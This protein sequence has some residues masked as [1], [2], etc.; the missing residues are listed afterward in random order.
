MAT[1]ISQ[2]RAVAPA[3]V[4]HRQA[5]RF[6]VTVSRAT[7]RKHGGTPMEA[8]LYDLSIYGCRFAIPVNFREGQRLWLRLDGSIPIAAAVIWCKEGFV[9]CRFDETIERGLVRDLTLTIR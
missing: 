5:E 7:V 4:E 8:E 6:K 3:L 1:R 2:F 9:G